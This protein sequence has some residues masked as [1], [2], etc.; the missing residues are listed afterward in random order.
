MDKRQPGIV[1][2]HADFK[3]S[4]DVELL[5]PWHDACGCYL[6]LRRNDDNFVAK[7]GTNA[8]GKFTAQNNAESTC[9]QRVEPAGFHVH[10]NVGDLIFVGWNNAAHNTA[11][12]GLVI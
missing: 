1:L 12:H 11:L 2:V 4:N 6:T 7:A 10:A 3:N 9:L 8:E 5:E